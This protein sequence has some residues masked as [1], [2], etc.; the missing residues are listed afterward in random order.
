MY[1]SMVTMIV[2]FVV[3]SMI[4]PIAPQLQKQFGLTEFQK[5]LLVATPVLL[6]SLFRIP[7][8]MFTDR[9]GGRRVYTLLMLFLLVPLFGI[10]TAHTFPLFVFWEVLLGIAGTSFAVGIGHVSAWFPPKKQG[11]VLGITALGNV[12]TA[13]AGFTIPSLFLHLGF[14][15]MAYALMVPVVLSALVLWFMTRDARHYSAVS[16]AE[17]RDNVTPIS[18]LAGKGDQSSQPFW[19]VG[20]LWLLSFYYFIT[21]GGFVA[22]GN[23]LPTLLQ[24]QLHLAP[25]DAGLRAA[26]FVLLATAMRPIGG[27]L[28]DRVS[29]ASLLLIA[30]AVIGVGSVIWA[31]GIKSLFV[32]T[33][34]ALLIAVVLGIGNGSVFKMVPQYFPTATGKA[35]G[36]VGAL[37]GI[38]GFFPPLIMG[39]F[40]QNTGSFTGGFLLLTIVAAIAFVLILFTGVRRNS[41]PSVRKGRVAAL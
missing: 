1:V 11:L 16:G 28:A 30:F 22:F 3:W 15:G 27:Y 18:S 9:F 4:S 34:C 36:I 12:G 8:G 35:T 6:G 24:G 17:A 32:T 5:S 39:A 14:S 10:T 13:V 23:Y 21:F 25:V 19:S 26:G 31:Y 29:P 33:A 7:I 2:A 20:Q 37:G 40:R 38:G 41:N